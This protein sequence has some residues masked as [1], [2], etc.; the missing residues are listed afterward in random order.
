MVRTDPTFFFDDNN[1]DPRL[2][3][4]QV[5]RM[6]WCIGEPDEVAHVLRQAHG[7][8]AIAIAAQRARGCRD[9][10]RVGNYH[11]WMAVVDVLQGA[12]LVV[13]DETLC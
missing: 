7:E 6:L 5:R 3:R 10:G 4:G 13:Q 1:G 2:C 8:D 11:F 12:A 9:A